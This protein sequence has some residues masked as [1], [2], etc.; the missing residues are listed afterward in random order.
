MNICWVVAFFC[1]ELNAQTASIPLSG[2]RR[3][4][5]LSPGENNPRNS[6]GSFITLKHHRILFVYSHYTG[7]STSDHAK[8]YL[9]SR[10][11]DDGGQ[12]WSSQD[13]IEIAQEGK[14]NVMSVSLLR[15]QN[16]QI[17]LFYLR[18]DAI[19]DCTPLV[20]FSKDEGQSWSAPISCINDQAGYFVLN[21]DRVIQLKSGRLLMAVALHQ[22]KGSGLWSNTGKLF[23]Y[24]SDDQG[25][26][27]HIGSEVPNPEKIVTQEPGLVEL[28]NDSI[29]MFIR[30][31][32]GVQCR[33]FSK[34]QGLTWTPVERTQIASPLS[35]ASIKRIPSTGDLFMVWNNNDG[36]N[37]ALKGKRTPL[38]MAISKDEGKTWEYI[39]N[40][41]TDPDGWYCYMA[42]HFIRKNI[43]LGY[44]AGSQ[45]KKQI[46]R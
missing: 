29:F 13:K 19:D 39:K 28:K 2:F 16:G 25:L 18:K 22:V 7:V 20:R 5:S 17:A 23:S 37:L 35:P 42:I 3:E 46:Y 8:A 15:L 34:D 43:L 33:S 45:S 26:S 9:A 41:E 12:T 24:F 36:S 31:G 40:I 11:S 4:L 10:Y 6:E 21:N 14:M 30:S 44:C 32:A 38:T 1:L 27:W